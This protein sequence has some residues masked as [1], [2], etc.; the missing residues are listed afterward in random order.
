ML[1]QAEKLLLI[2]R[3]TVIIEEVTGAAVLEDVDLVS[4]CEDLL[5]CVRLLDLG[6]GGGTGLSLGTELALT[7]G[8]GDGVIVFV[9]AAFLLVVVAF[10]SK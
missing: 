1:E 3:G 10:L 9:L 7:G 2:A 6:G 5:E 4:E 8:G